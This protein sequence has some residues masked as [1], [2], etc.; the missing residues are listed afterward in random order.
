MMKAVAKYKKRQVDIPIT[1]QRV[2][3]NM[4][5]NPVFLNPPAALAQLKTVLPEFRTSLVN[6]EGRDKHMVS[7]KNDKKAIVLA[8]LQELAEYV[9]VTCNGDRTLILSSGFDATNANSSGS[10]LPPSAELVE[11]E[12]GAAGV[13]TT[14]AKNVTGAKAYVHQ[15]CKEQPNT[16]TEWN[17]QFNELLYVRRTEFRQALL[18][19]RCCH[20]QPRTKRLFA[21]CFQGHSIT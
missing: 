19:P 3:E 14:R 10:N 18:V 9:T 16:N 5:N 2:I 20:W 7:I 17:R 21:G 4:E 13:A 1:C 8:L 6:A 11:V 15:Y 12:L